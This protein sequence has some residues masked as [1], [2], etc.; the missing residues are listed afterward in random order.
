[1]LCSWKLIWAHSDLVD[2]HSEGCTICHRYVITPGQLVTHCAITTCPSRCHP[3]PQ[4]PV[5]QHSTVHLCHIDIPAWPLMLIATPHCYTNYDTHKHIVDTDTGVT[6]ML[7]TTVLHFPVGLVLPIPCWE[8][9]CHQIYNT[10]CHW[11]YS[12]QHWVYSSHNTQNDIGQR[13]ATLQ[14]SRPRLVDM[15]LH[16]QGHVIHSQ[17]Q[18]TPCT[19]V[20]G[21]H[22]GICMALHLQCVTL[23]DLSR[24]TSSCA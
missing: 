18:A 11:V 12:S 5:C 1:M 8:R 15:I 4:L 17:P 3:F 7:I 24:H 13:F 16:L 19:I 14:T 22:L 10:P 23:R 2:N 21:G 20:A 9:S 6:F